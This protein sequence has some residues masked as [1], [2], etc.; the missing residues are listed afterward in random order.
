MV[1]YPWET[2]PAPLP[3]PATEVVS[4]RSHGKG[5]VYHRATSSGV[6]IL[7]GKRVPC[8]T[9]EAVGTVRT[10]LTAKGAET[11]AAGPCTANPV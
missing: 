6:E 9:C 2:F 1:P 8:P 7:A 11:P 4:P 5:E 10:P 3:W